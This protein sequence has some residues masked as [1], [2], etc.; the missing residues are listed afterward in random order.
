MSDN[1]LSLD[2]KLFNSNTI[3]IIYSYNNIL[4]IPYTIEHTINST[5]NYGIIF[6]YNNDNTINI[7]T[8]VYNV[9]FEPYTIKIFNE[10]YNINSESQIISII[11]VII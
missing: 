6:K 1:I 8:I 4:C 5:Y 2:N 3:N 11:Q 10:L 7:N 9:K